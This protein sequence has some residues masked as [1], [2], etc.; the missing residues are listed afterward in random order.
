VVGRGATI[1]LDVDFAGVRDGKVGQF[2]AHPDVAA[3]MVQ[4]AP[5]PPGQVWALCG[6]SRQVR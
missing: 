5:G 1:D 2:S 3:L 6:C 4:L